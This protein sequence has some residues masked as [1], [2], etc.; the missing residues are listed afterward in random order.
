[1]RETNYSE[2]I[3]SGHLTSTYRRSTA[4]SVLKSSDDTDR[5]Y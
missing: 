3:S 1:M 5:F 2:E 4:G